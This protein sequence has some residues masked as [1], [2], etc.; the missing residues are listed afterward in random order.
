MSRRPMP[1]SRPAKGDDGPA[2]E[3]DRLP[4]TPHPRETERLFGQE[5]AEADFLHAH[6]SGRM[7]HAWLLTGPQGI[8]KATFAWRAARFLLAT[9][10]AGEDGL[11]GAPPPPESLDI[12]SEHPV[13]RR[14]RALSE[15]GLFLLQRPFNDKTKKLATAITVDEARRLKGFFGLSAPDGGAR[16][17]LVGGIHEHDALPAIGRGQAEELNP[18]A[19]NA[20]LKLLE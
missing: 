7:H 5:A 12:A 8:G 14:V 18:S 16:V 4:G 1:G 6:A 20:L 19:A 11:F 15:P 10:A 13:A 2:P 17:Q 9:P 3:A